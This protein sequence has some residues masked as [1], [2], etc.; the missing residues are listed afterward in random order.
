MRY[1]TI[2]ECIFLLDLVKVH[3]KQL[4]IDWPK[5]TLEL[6]YK[7]QMKDLPSKKFDLCD[8]VLDLKVLVPVSL[9]LF[10]VVFSFLKRNV[11]CFPVFHST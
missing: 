8:V 5:E 9:E 3:L 11:I 2:V 1:I 6:I 7:F 4:A 10:N